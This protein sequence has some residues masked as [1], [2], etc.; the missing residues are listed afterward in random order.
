MTMKM[1]LLRHLPMCVRNFGPLWVFSC[2]P[3]ESTNGFVKTMVH[4]TRYVATQVCMSRT[5]TNIAIKTI[6]LI[7]LT[8]KFKFTDMRYVDVSI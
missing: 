4:G 3:Y 8:F 7:Q 5:S 1:H 2:F 6:A